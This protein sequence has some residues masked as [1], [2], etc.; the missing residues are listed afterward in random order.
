[1]KYNN[2]AEIVNKPEKYRYHEPRSKRKDTYPEG[3]RLAAEKHWKEPEVSTQIDSVIGNGFE[4]KTEEEREEKG[5][6]I[7]TC[8]LLARYISRGSAYIY[9]LTNSYKKKT[10]KNSVF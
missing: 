3:L 6:K 4:E 10:V 8:L 7:K 1:M 9:I 5:K 2:S